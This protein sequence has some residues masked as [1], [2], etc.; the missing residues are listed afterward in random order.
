MDNK[1]WIVWLDNGQD[2][3]DHECWIVDIRNDGFEVA[4]QIGATALGRFWDKNECPKELRGR[5]DCAYGD[6]YPAASFM[7]EER[8]LNSYQ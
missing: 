1:I 5:E 3:D 6:G 8:I 7:I 2:Y 4:S